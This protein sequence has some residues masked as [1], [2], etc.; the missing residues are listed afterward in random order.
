VKSKYFQP[1]TATAPK[2]T[3]TEIDLTLTWSSKKSY[4]IMFLL[5]KSIHFMS[6]RSFFSDCIRLFL[7][8]Y[9]F[10]DPKGE[11]SNLKAS[12]K[13]RADKIFIWTVILLYYEKKSYFVQ[14]FDYFFFFFEITKSF[15]ES[16]KTKPTEQH[17]KY[18]SLHF[19]SC[20]FHFSFFVVEWTTLKAFTTQNQ[21]AYLKLMRSN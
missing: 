6:T 10:S 1:I 13:K 19:F 20:A 2:I 17:L 15:I 9:S 11:V 4:I 5:V 3:T 16:K 14:K 12:F 7:F 21:Q 8:S 18:K